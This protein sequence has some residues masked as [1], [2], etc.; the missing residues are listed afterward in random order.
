MELEKSNVRTL[1]SIL[2]L[3]LFQAVSLTAQVPDDRKNN[4]IGG[5]EVREGEFSF[6]V[7][8]PFCTGTIIAPNW[9]LT[10]AHCVSP[11]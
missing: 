1:L 8:T 5:E 10:A 4:I 11:P 6:V 9:V 2:V 3:G 7:D